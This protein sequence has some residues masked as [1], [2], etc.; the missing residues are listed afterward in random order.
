MMSNTLSGKIPTFVA[1]V[2]YVFEHS[3]SVA[4]VGAPL[5]SREG[6]TVSPV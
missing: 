5:S 2:E 6:S 1:I 4:V 3:T